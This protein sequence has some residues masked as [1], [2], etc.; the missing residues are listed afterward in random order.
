M[1]GP[2]GQRPVGLFEDPLRDYVGIVA[3]EGKWEGIIFQRLVVF[4]PQEKG[5][6]P[7]TGDNP[8]LRGV[9]LV[10]LE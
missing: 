1:G 4:S 6:K 8:A 10:P 3:G 7:S 2:S 5:K 9:K